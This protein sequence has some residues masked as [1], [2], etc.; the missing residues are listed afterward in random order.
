MHISERV[1]CVNQQQI[2]ATQFSPNGHERSPKSAPQWSKSV[3]CVVGFSQI[4][5]QCK[6]AQAKKNVFYH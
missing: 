5:R 4:A 2:L 6:R 3:K 1:R